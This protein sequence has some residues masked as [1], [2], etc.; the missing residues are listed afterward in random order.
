[1]NSQMRRIDLVCKLLG[2]LGIS[3]IDSLSPIFAV[4]ATLGMNVTSVF[5]EYWY[6]NQVYIG[7]PALE[8]RSSP[9]R[10]VS[11]ASGQNT[12]G[13]TATNRTAIHWKCLSL[14][15]IALASWT[16][17]L[18]FYMNH[19]AFLPSIS[20]SLL[21]LNVLS[22]SGQMITFLLSIP[23]GDSTTPAFSPAVIGGL[24]TVSTLFELSATWV[25]PRLTRRLGVVRA[26][27]WALSWQ[28]IWLAGGLGWFFYPPN[29]SHLV[30]PSILEFN[31]HPFSDSYQARATVVSA[32]GLITA[33]VFSRVGLWTFDLCVQLIVQ[34]EVQSSHRGAFSS[35]ETSFQNAFEMVAFALTIVFYKPSHFWAPM[36]VSVASVFLAGGL[37]TAFVRKRRG[38]LF[39]FEKVRCSCQ[40]EDETMGVR[41]PENLENNHM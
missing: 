2:P 38:H 11:F 30:M 16:C 31:F 37:Y 34:D 36:V 35:T 27:I 23:C 28:M 1:M 10:S 4:W 29:L 26:G 3:F 6:I 13:L 15:R 20:L 21:Y 9:S 32:S 41:D 14:F 39:H 7:C 33:V 25:A 24:R 18:H 8:R 22:F 5:P 17:N 12:L 40:T 19:R